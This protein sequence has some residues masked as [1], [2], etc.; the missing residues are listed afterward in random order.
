MVNEQVDFIL[1]FTWFF[2]LVLCDLLLAFLLGINERKVMGFD[3]KDYMK[4]YRKKNK[5]KIKAYLVANRDKIKAR[6]RAYDKIN[7]D[8]RKAYKEVNKDKTKA[9]MK[10]YQKAYY[11]AHKDKIKAYYETNKVKNKAKRKVYC[12]A[13]RDKRNAYM[14]VYQ[15]DNKDK[16]KARKKLYYDSNKDKIKAR[17]KA[18][19]MINK[20]KTNARRTA[21]LK[22]NINAR[23]AHNIRSRVRLALKNNSKSA[24]TMTL[25]GCDIPYLKSYL[26]KQFNKKMNWDNYG[27]HWHIDHI[28]PCSRFDLQ[29]ADE[30]VRC[31]HYS[32]LQPL[33]ADVN[34]S[35]GDRLDHPVQVV[36]L[37]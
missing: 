26:A 9:Y 12:Q 6:Q 21:Y 33:Q 18:Y 1:H 19:T 8:K 36:L 32:N 10:V 2:G 14:K 30:Q 24:N 27:S 15:K 28:V 35:K 5:D 16:I 25:I 3:K 13:N 17:E 4:E 34:I 23:V 11:E 29:R 20:D 22:N 31:F 7:K 37:S